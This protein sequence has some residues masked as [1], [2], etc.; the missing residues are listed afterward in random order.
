MAE[1]KT[2]R[3]HNVIRKWAESRGGHPAT[4]TATA[5]DSKAG[6][7]RLD[8]D[9]KDDSLEEVSWDR[10]FEK[11]DGENLSFLYQ[12]ETEDGKKSR[13]HKFINA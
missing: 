7:L 10:F 12:D 8:F 4:V 11:F 1:A 9:P 6:I 5:R 13:F 2:T 3:D